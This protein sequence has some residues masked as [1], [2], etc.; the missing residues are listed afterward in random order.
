M[1]LAREVEVLPEV[2]EAMESGALG[3]EAAR[4][5][6]RIETPDNV[7]AWVARARVSHRR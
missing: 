2:A 5:V 4:L 7:E 1:N 6:C 3:F